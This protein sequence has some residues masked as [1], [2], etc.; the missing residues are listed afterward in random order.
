MEHRLS[1][2]SSSFWPR[3]ALS[4][5]EPW[6][7]PASDP[8]LALWGAPSCTSEL[9][10][11]SFVTAAACSC[12]ASASRSLAISRSPA[13]AALSASLQRDSRANNRASCFLKSPSQRWCLSAMSLMCSRI[14]SSIASECF[15]CLDWAVSAD[16]VGCGGVALRA[17]SARLRYFSTCSSACSAKT[18]DSSSEQWR[19]VISALSLAA[20]CCASACITCLA[21]ACTVFKVLDCACCCAPSSII[22]VVR[23]R[24]SRS[25]V[26]HLWSVSSSIDTAACWDSSAFCCS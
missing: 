11:S 6:R 10:S 8:R 21:H 26:W 24:S 9:L 15:D 23:S 12:D 1:C 17:S 7:E 14:S 25:S 2:C 16:S 3:P 19:C 5:G 20:S 13:R 18:L 4:G 22:T